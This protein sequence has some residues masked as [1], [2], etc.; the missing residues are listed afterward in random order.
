[1]VFWPVGRERG[2]YR[3]GDAVK[4]LNIRTTRV[5]RLLDGR[6]RQVHHH[7]SIEDAKLLADYQSAVRSPKG[8]AATSSSTPK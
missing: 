8:A 5:F 2:T 3:D 1:M 7:G 4:Y 6:W